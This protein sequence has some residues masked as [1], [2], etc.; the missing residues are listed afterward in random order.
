M[1]IFL[2]SSG[3]PQDH[4][5][6]D[7][8]L[9]AKKSIIFFISTGEANLSYLSQFRKRVRLYNKK[10]KIYHIDL[11]KKHKNLKETFLTADLIYFS[12]GNTFSLKK[13]LLNQ[14]LFDTNFWSKLLEN[15]IILAGHSAGAIIMSPSIRTAAYPKFDRDDN[16]VKIKNFK[17]LNLFN[18]ELM[19]HAS[20]F[21]SKTLNKLDKKFKIKLKRLN[22]GDF[23]KI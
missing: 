16:F 20:N 11:F 9:F 15:N 3:E 21:S 8:N 10:A 14:K 12:G 6:V 23:I 7:K 4:P 2:F 17:G 1:S 19:P 5:T 22:D 18:F 13:G